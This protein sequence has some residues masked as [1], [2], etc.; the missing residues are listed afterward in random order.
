M[1]EHKAEGSS[2]ALDESTDIDSLDRVLTRLALLDASR[3]NAVVHNL[4][5]PILARID[6][7]KPKV[8]SKAVEVLSHIR[9]RIS[10]NPKDAV[11][12][13]QLLQL[14]WEGTK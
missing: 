14:F 3:L 9:R 11:P 2:N 7:V 5:P 13:P 10:A 12:F 4:L 6:P 1:S 8:F